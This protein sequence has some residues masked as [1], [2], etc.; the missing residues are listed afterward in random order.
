MVVMLRFSS[1][2]QNQPARWPLLVRELLAH[3]G[4][5]QQIRLPHGECWQLSC[6]L[7]GCALQRRGV[8]YIFSVEQLLQKESGL[9]PAPSSQLTRQQ[10]KELLQQLLLSRPEPGRIYYLPN[11]K[12]ECGCLLRR[13]KGGF[14][15]I[16]QPGS[17]CSFTPQQ[18]TAPDSPQRGVWEQQ[19]RQAK[20]L[21]DRMPEWGSVAVLLPEGKKLESCEY[22]DISA[23]G[24]V[25]A[26]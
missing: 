3:S 11:A 15:W 24:S 10:G 9:P 5:T 6:S 2:P 1:D 8:S 23:D 12:P 18:L 26:P 7:T 22:L 19:R 17:R 20:A 25:S 4:C 14:T 16:S 13:E 21:L